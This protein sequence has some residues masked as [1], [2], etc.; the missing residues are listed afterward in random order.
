MDPVKG[1]RS[2]AQRQPN[3]RTARI[4]EAHSVA[5][6]VV[7]GNDV[8]AVADAAGDL[9]HRARC[10]EGPGYLEAVTY[11]WRGHVG[12]DENIDVGL[13][14]SP[15]E[16]AAWKR[17]DPVGR[18]QSAMMD[19]GDTSAD[20]LEAIAG[21]VDRY[22]DEAARRAYHAPW[23]EQSALLDYVYVNNQD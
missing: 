19:R 8:I 12:P 5:A 18:L 13:R 15:E 20:E 16:L 14:R 9:I 11:R 3:D 22:V 2:I 21:E 7:D 6:S 23:P 4:A 1:G 10:G 17:R